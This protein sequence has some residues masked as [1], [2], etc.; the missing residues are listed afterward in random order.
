MLM[1]PHRS[2]DAI[3]KHNEKRRTP[4]VEYAA[5]S[6]VYQDVRSDDRTILPDG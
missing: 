3:L 5:F 4:E 1:I 2:K 6:L